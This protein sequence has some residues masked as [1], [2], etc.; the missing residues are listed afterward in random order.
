MSPVEPSA[1]RR[2]LTKHGPFF[3]MSTPKNLAIGPPVGYPVGRVR[4]CTRIFE[5]GRSF[6][7][8][9]FSDSFPSTKAQD[10]NLSTPLRLSHGRPRAITVRRRM[11]AHTLLTHARQNAPLDGRVQRRHSQ[12]SAHGLARVRAR[13]ARVEHTRAASRTAARRSGARCGTLGAPRPSQLSF[14]SMGCCGWL[15]V[16][17]PM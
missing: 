8:A 6:F 4:S 1:E 15:V 11:R 16:S 3:V 10:N 17:R 12:S 13:R 2:S 14:F 9:N 5:H 7:R